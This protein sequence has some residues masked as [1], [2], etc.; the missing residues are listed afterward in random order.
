MTGGFIDLGG[1]Q[2]HHHITGPENAPA[3]L[4][5]HGAS[6]SYLEPYMALSTALAG[7]LYDLEL[8]R[9]GIPPGGV[10]V[11][12]DCFEETFTVVGLVSTFGW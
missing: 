7:H 4:V 3:L 2:L 5:L 6:T 1:V 12:K 10:C 11:G 9:K 8:K